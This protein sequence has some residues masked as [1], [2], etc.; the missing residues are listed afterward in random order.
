MHHLHPKCVKDTRATTTCVCCAPLRPC[1]CPSFSQS[2]IVCVILIIVYSSAVY[3]VHFCVHYFN[4]CYMV[5][6]PFK[7]SLGMALMN[8]YNERFPIRNT[9]YCK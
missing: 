4:E 3:C 2:T 6:Q 8:P 9:T 7:L 5:G 1:L